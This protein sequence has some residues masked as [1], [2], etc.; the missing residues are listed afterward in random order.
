MLSSSFHPLLKTLSQFRSFDLAQGEDGNSLEFQ[1]DDRR[2][3]FLV[4]DTR[5]LCYAELCVLIDNGNGM[6][7][8]TTRIFTERAR[9]AA[10]MAH[11]AWA[12]LFESG[13]DDGVFY[14]AREFIDGERLG[15]YVE[16][17]GP[18]PDRMAL[19][20]VIQ[21]GEALLAL[22]DHP[23]VVAEVDLYDARLFCD[24]E[25]FIALK[26]P[27]FPL[28]PV[29]RRPRGSVAAVSSRLTEVFRRLG[30]RGGVLLQSELDPGDGEAFPLATLLRRMREI[31]E[32]SPQ[33][34]LS[35]DLWPRGMLAEQIY[36]RRKPKEFLSHDFSSVPNAEDP[37]NAYSQTLV[38]P[39]GKVLRLQVLP[40][41]R[42]LR[43]DFLSFLKAGAQAAAIAVHAQWKNDDFRLLAEETAPGR[44]LAN[45]LRKGE[46]LS[47][48]EE[49]LLLERISAAVVSLE[50]GGVTIPD[51]RP[52]NVFVCFEDPANVDLEALADQR[53]LTVW[54]DFHIRLR[55]H[56]TM[57]G[58]THPP[59]VWGASTSSNAV[60]E[61]LSL[62]GQGLRE[63]AAQLVVE[64][65]QS[66]ARALAGGE[67]L[68]SGEKPEGVRPEFVE[69]G[70]GEVFFSGSELPGLSVAAQEDVLPLPQDEDPGAWD[71]SASARSR[72]PEGADDTESDDDYWE[73][74]PEAPAA[75]WGEMG[76]VPVED[77]GEYED[78]EEVAMAEGEMDWDPDEEAEAAYSGPVLSPIAAAMVGD[79][80]LV[81][82]GAE[83]VPEWE[84]GR[85]G[86]GWLWILLFLVGAG[87]CG[88][89]IAHYTGQGFWLK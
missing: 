80:R 50:A 14:Y 61:Y 54:P 24:S 43:D 16:R 30:Q 89:A 6:D 39:K 32:R 3:V 35:S 38:G 5:R 44:S 87:L 27:G 49:N 37:W 68:E 11:P 76:L 9:V 46:K 29:L 4:F 52:E 17:V 55:T 48:G 26:M 18:L 7:E 42:L 62:R 66:S 79:D 41:P 85:R 82:D 20:I 45:L 12:A 47:L 51:F 57:S 31:C 8:A 28:E 84:P 19:E 58:L 10:S 36:R 88:I 63:K 33:R 1:R 21:L 23:A 60:F 81:E 77:E 40:P 70:A 65:A 2:V 56:L 25:G 86:T 34:E 75:I 73:D 71:E 15:D 64:V 78:D 13:V 83:L 67:D 72:S 53:P 74:D 22:E 69:P 59:D